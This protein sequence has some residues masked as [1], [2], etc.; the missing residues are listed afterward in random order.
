[1]QLRYLCYV[2]QTGYSVAAQEYIKAILTADPDF[3]IQVTSVNDEKTQTGIST[4]RRVWLNKMM[5][6][7]PRNPHVFLQH[8]VPTIYKRSDAAK[9]VGMALFETINVPEKWI[10]N[11]NHLDTIIT[12]SEFNKNIF[13]QHGVKTPIHVIPH[14]FD[15]EMFNRKVEPDGRFDKFTFLSIGTW[16]DRK[17]WEC[18]IK[19]FYDA[20]QSKDNVCLLIKTDKPQDL[21]DMV[22]RIKRTCEWRGKD[23]AP[24]FSEDRKCC[25]FEDIPSI[26]KKGD[27]YVCPSLGEGFGYPGLHAMALGIPLITTRFGGCLQYAR[28]DFCNYVEPSG[29]QTVYR[30]DGIPQ[31]KNCIWPVIKISTLRDALRQAFEKPDYEKAEAAYNFVHRDF[32][33]EAIGSQLIEVITK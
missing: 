5:R 12:A 28:P 19:A 14:C 17:N 11:M 33:Y 1:M 31:F 13:Q 23:T 16:K 22:L 18:L 21:Q 9:H 8:V 32:T 20:F 3:D 24:I 26:M 4:D 2:N 27:I 30:M 25:Q 10:E 15:P 7:K 29:Y 6:Q